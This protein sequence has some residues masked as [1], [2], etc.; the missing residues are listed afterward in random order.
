M[1][2]SF[3]PPPC[4]PPLQKQEK[5]MAKIG[6]RRIAQDLG[7]SPAAVSLALNGKSG[8]SEV[9]R[10]RVLR[11]AQALGYGVKK[12]KQT[13][14]IQLLIYKKHGGVVASTPFF[15][16]LIEQTTLQ[17]MQDGYHLNLSYFYEHQDVKE[18]LEALQSVDIAGCLLLATEMFGADI[19]HFQ[20]MNIPIVVMDNYF[21]T[22]TFD[23]VLINNL[24][25]VRNAVQYLK[26]CGHT[27]IGYIAS[28]SKIRNFSERTDGFCFAMKRSLGSLQSNHRYVQLSH[29]SEGAYKDM[30]AYLAKT[31]SLPTAFFA[32]DDLLAIS[33]VRALQRFGYQVPEDI[34]IMGFDNISTAAL[35]S[36]PLTTM[37][38]SRK[39]L[40]ILAVKCLIAR[41]QGNDQPPFTIL[42]NSNLVKRESVAVIS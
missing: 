25:G 14:T 34:S 20:G 12:R 36:P 4:G 15:D 9:T 37:G 2:E 32:E 26:S 33:V 13:Q 1:T 18:Q 10:D 30:C 38:V 16:Q 31:N 24:Y 42:V 21:P 5:P 7:L 40:G 39:Q 17:A 8:V 11:Y 28:G 35:C 23:C 29:T 27:D 3:R 19:Q 41:I 22:A 6:V